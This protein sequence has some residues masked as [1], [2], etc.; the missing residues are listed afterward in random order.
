MKD[1]APHPMRLERLRRGWTQRELADFAQ[2]SLSSVERAE[3]WEPLRVD[4][5]KRLCEALGKARPEDLGLRA[6]GDPEES[7]KS[8][9]RTYI[10]KGV[11]YT[12]DQENEE[13]VNRRLALKVL[14]S[15][16]TAIFAPHDLL[17][18][19]TW[20]AFSNGLEESFSVDNLNHFSKLTEASWYLLKSSELEVLDRVLSSY[21]PK[22]TTLA[23]VSSQY[24]ESAAGL[25][26]QS[27]QIKGIL[28]GHKLNL[29]ERRGDHQLAVQYGLLSKDSNIR[30]ASL[31]QLASAFQYLKHPIKVQETYESVL[32]FIEQISPLLRSCVYLGL[33]DTLAQQGREQDALRNLS[34][35]HESF[36]RQPD[37]DPM[38]LTSDAGFFSLSLYDGL[39]Y[40]NLDQ[41]KKA[42]EALSRIETYP[43]NATP[44]RVRI[45]IINLQAEAAIAQTDL[46]RS[47]AC[48]EIGAKGAI[49]IK[50]QKRFNEAYEAY[51]HMRL[52]WRKEARVKELADLFIA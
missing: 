32:P 16:G 36:P 20:E 23:Q 10:H 43:K 17:K 7:T 26:S 33:A 25:A 38:F 49:A 27:Y 31:I 21:L 37:K 48:V 35:A 39:T 3:R 50:S 14:S 30:A 12:L 4:I 34:L 9:E 5:C 8:E 46:E 1:R 15:A 28:A 18:P 42:Y 40:L 41:P 13:E 24:Q 22:L 45:E 29:D 19:Q 44:E 11:V 47:Y 2:V 6:H 51:Q 52:I